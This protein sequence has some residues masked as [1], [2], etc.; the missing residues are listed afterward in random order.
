MFNQ[1]NLLF[2]LVEPASP[3][4]LEVEGIPAL[5]DSG[6]KN[7]PPDSMIEEELQKACSVADLACYIA[8]GD[9]SLQKCN[10]FPV[11]WTPGNKNWERRAEDMDSQRNRGVLMAVKLKALVCAPN[12]LPKSKRALNS[13]QSHVFLRYYL[14]PFQRGQFSVG[15]LNMGRD[16]DPGESPARKRPAQETASSEAASDAEKEEPVQNELIDEDVEEGELVEDEAMDQVSQEA[17]ITGEGLEGMFEEG[18]WVDGIGSVEDDA[19]TVLEE[20][21]PT[22]C[23]DGEYRPWRDMGFVG[24]EFDFP[25][26]RYYDYDDDAACNLDT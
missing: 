7:H 5:Q 3:A 10:S 8:A 17:G 14:A 22:L 23:E 16:L 12:P 1:L 15:I 18:G 9:W 24:M 19:L 13:L 6:G 25:G 4:T 2:W 20:D 11:P 21:P 26:K